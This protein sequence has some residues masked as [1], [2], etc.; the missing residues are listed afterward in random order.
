M[1]EF[2]KNNFTDEELAKQ[3]QELPNA[4]PR[5]PK[6]IERQWTAIREALE[7]SALS[8][9]PSA[10]SKEV[11]DSSAFN[12]EASTTNKPLWWTAAVAAVVTLAVIIG[13]VPSG[14]TPTEPSNVNNSVAEVKPATPPTNW[15]QSQKKTIRSLEQANSQY[16]LAL[17]NKMQSQK[18]DIPQDYHAALT[19]LQSAKKQYISQLSQNPNDIHLYKKLLNSYSKERA[20]LK[21][22]LS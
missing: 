3:L 4:L 6:N 18:S 2:D 8:K 1:S 5:S 13:G 19:G 21:L 7:P 10:V 16:Y 9:E 22:L 12:K 20:L 17:G 15:V 11:K 14:F